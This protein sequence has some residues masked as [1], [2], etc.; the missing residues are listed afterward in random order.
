MAEPMT[1]TAFKEMAEYYKQCME[2]KPDVFALIATVEHLYKQLDKLE[3]TKH[4]FG[5]GEGLV[6]AHRHSNGGGWVADTAYVEDSVYVG[7]FAK[8]YGDARVYGNAQVFGDAQVY[9]DALVYGNTEVY[10][11]AHISNNLRIYGNAEE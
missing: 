3:P 7:E 11:N 6:P 9:G 2:P 4:D 5:D 8:V 10:G 1:K